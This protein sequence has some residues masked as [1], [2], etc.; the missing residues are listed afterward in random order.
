MWFLPKRKGE[1][2]IKCLF[3]LQKDKFEYIVAHNAFVEK[4]LS[5]NI[6]HII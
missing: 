2:A 6:S 4:N 5:K 3:S 1:K